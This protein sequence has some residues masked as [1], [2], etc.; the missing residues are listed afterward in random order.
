[1]KKILN[2]LKLIDFEMLDACEILFSNIIKNG[3]KDVN[4]ALSTLNSHVICKLLKLNESFIS[5]PHRISKVINRYIDRKE[6]NKNEINWIY[7]ILKSLSSDF[8]LKL[9]K[10]K[11]I[12]LIFLIVNEKLNAS[13]QKGPLIKD[14]EID[15]SNNFLFKDIDKVLLLMRNEFTSFSDVV[16]S[17]SR[18]VCDIQLQNYEE[19]RA[20][21]NISMNYMTN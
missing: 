3:K 9:P 13:T 16:V 8:V 2:L 12:D 4:H 18:T 14:I 11:P 19:I 17:I 6:C 10:F 1:M 15:V 5:D 7:N 21:F 20:Y